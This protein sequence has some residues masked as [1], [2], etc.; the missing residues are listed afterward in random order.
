[1]IILD[2]LTTVVRMLLA[3]M[4]QLK[5]TKSHLAELMFQFCT[6]RS[7]RH[8]LLHL[9]VLSLKTVGETRSGMHVIHLWGLLH[10]FQRI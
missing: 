8:P 1:M 4:C 7:Q 9:V 3:W 5:S 6:D 2:C 10:K